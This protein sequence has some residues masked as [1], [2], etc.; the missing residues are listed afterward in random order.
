MSVTVE[1]ST[2]LVGLGANLP[3]RFGPPRTTLEKALVA[4]RASGIEIVRRAPWYGSHAVPASS[5]PPYVNGAARISTDLEPAELLA[6]LHQ[7]EA[8]FGRTRGKRNA[9]RILDL[10]LL[11][12]GQRVIDSTDGLMLPHPRLHERAF[13]VVPLSDIAPDW[14]HPKLGKTIREL[15]ALT[16]VG[17]VVWRIPAE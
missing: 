11:A 13:V 8:D 2:I 14:V 5:Q 9:A 7:I 3:S 6:R 15:R 17:D 4:L 10:D 1:T 16:D 12:Y